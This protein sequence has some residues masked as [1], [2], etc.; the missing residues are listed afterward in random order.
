MIE[1]IIGITEFLSIL[2]SI[3]IK[4]SFHMKIINNLMVKLKKISQVYFKTAYLR[5]YKNTNIELKV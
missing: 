5:L 1:I 2:A 4:K 3:Y